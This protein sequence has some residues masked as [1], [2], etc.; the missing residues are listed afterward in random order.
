[1]R[2]GKLSI[3]IGVGLLVLGLRLDA[4]LFNPANG[5]V[6]VSIVS[7]S[8]NAASGYA[9]SNGGRLAVVRNAAENTFIAQNFPGARIGL[10]DASLE[11]T[12]VW[13]ADAPYGYRNWLSGEPNNQGNEDEVQVLAS[14]LWNDVPAILNSSYVVEFPKF[15]IVSPISGKVFV[16]GSP[17]LTMNM[18]RTEAASM[19]A[20]L[21][22]FESAAEE[23]AIAAELRK[24]HPGLQVAV[25][26]S[27]EA[28]EGTFVWATGEPLTYSRWG[29]GEPNN[30]GNEDHVVMTLTLTSTSWNDVDV[31]SAVKRG[32]YEI[33][34]IVTAK[35]NLEAYPLNCNPPF[36]NLP[37]SPMSVIVRT[38]NGGGFANESILSMPT[39]GG[40]WAYV[41]GDTGST[42][43]AG[44]P[45]PAVTDPAFD[46]MAIGIPYGTIAIALDWEFI[47]AEGPQLPFNDAMSI[48]VISPTG[49]LVGNLMYADTFTDF[50]PGTMATYNYGS[51]CIA[52]PGTPV[53]PSGKKS[54]AAVFV[55][56]GG[57]STIP[58]GSYLSISCRNGSDTQFTSTANVDN[59]R[60]V[61]RNVTL[62]MSAPTGAG[63]FRLGTRF[64]Q[65]GALVFRGLTV[66]SIPTTPGWFYGIDIGLG[67]I[68][69]QFGAG[70]PFVAFLDGNGEDFFTL[71]SGVV[72]GIPLVGVALEFTGGN[73]PLIVSKPAEFVTF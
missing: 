65:P 2:I 57:E 1:M 41:I 60:F 66:G 45:L 21:A 23:D 24:V 28:V 55:G 42:N 4:Q 34:D 11:G 71:T 35:V 32:L 72:P 56:N 48:D 19:G 9:R 40:T 31:N 30:S 33:D 63:S 49:T 50:I 68:A 10:T 70:Y 7:G 3:G 46:A 29:A 13:T 44:G 5:S 36:S 61:T 58:P 18:M 52:I 39:D 38:V 27:D 22:T 67:D 47:C 37:P 25:G 12:F 51:G 43:P 15:A 8:F 62:E 26:L 14:G 59:I 20:H 64:G 69:A 54:A 6:Y 73:P 16:L 53:M 17:F